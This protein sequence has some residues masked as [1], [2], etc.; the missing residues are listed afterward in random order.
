MIP[1]G[2]SNRDPQGYGGYSPPLLVAGF[3][4]SRKG[5]TERGPMIKM[6]ADDARIRLVSENEL[7]RIV[8]DR[9]Q[10]L[11][12]LQIDDSLPRG[13][14]VLRD[15]VGASISEVIRVIKLDTDAGTRA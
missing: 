2:K 9:R 10:E 14:V 1:T 15:V 8:T 6:R 11:A 5:D 3:I 7:V 13:S 12:E 4:S